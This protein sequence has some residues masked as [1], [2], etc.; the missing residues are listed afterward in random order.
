MHFFRFFYCCL[1]FS[2]FCTSPAHASQCS[3]EDREYAKSRNDYYTPDG[4][5]AFGLKVQQMVKNKDLQ[6]IFSL[7]EGEL[8][9]G[10]R[11]K[12]VSN[13]LF[14]EIFDNEWVE[15]VLSSESKCSPVGYRGFMLSR[16]MI[17][18][19]KSKTGWAIISINGAKEE[20]IEK[21]LVGWT[22]DKKIVHPVC[23]KRPWL[24]WD[25]FKA[26]SEFF[27]INDFEQ[28]L[29]TPGRFMGNSISDFAP[30]KPSW[31]SN[32]GYLNLRGKRDSECE[33]IALVAELKQCNLKN[34]DFEYK[35][36]KVWIKDSSDGY[37]VEYQYR[38]LNELTPDKCSELAPDI[39]VE[40]KESYLLS[41]GDYSGGSMG[42][43]ISY[44]IYGLFDLPKLG[45]SIVPL[46]FFPNKNEALNY[47]DKN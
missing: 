9:N 41:V 42:W 46:M 24:S 29:K 5:Y 15:L 34:F 20:N 22:I 30:I 8:I 35:D 25:N 32:D 26:F 33:N 17:W 37:D 7:V 11:K 23:F 21:P 39:G 38:I 4:A 2:V 36:G 28:F 16:G 19:D 6:G 18:Y 40:C 31:C 13:K 1:V 47:L 45:S 44:G 14:K 3:K 43:D 27:S 10:P 12:F